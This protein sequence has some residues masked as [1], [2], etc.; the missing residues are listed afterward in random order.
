MKHLLSITLLTFLMACQA[1][2][3]EPL[4]SVKANGT[5]LPKV[6]KD[7][8][9]QMHYNLYL[10]P[11]TTGTVQINAQNVPGFGAIDLILRTQ[12]GKLTYKVVDKTIVVGTPEKLS[13]LPSTLYHGK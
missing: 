11:G 2:A 5:P 9:Q 10:A 12:P 1:M 4:V 3:K 8:A 6:L 7:I 13:K